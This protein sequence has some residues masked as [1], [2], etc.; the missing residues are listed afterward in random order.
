[1]THQQALVALR[2]VLAS[3]YTDATTARRVASD[4]GLD[5]RQVS[6]STRALDNWTAILDEAEKQ[7]L[8]SDLVGIARK[9]YPRY[10][11]LADAAAAYLA[12]PVTPAAPPTS[13]SA[14]QVTSPAGPAA[15]RLLATDTIRQLTDA[16]VPAGLATPDARD[17]LLQGIYPGFVA[18]LPVRSSP[19]D[20][21]RSDL[22]AMN[23]VP[24]LVDGQVPLR[25]WLE[26]AVSRLRRTGYPEMASFQMVL[27][28]LDRAGEPR[29][30]PI[31]ASAGEPYSTIPF[32][33][34]HI[35]AGHFW[36]GSNRAQDPDALDNEMQHSVFLPEYRIARFPVTVAQFRR[37][38]DSTGYPTT[39]E[40]AGQAADLVR[41]LTRDEWPPKKG[42]CWRQPHGPGSRAH[43]EHPVTCISWYDAVEFCKWAKVRLPNE[44]EW[45]KAAGW[46]PQAQLKRI[47]PWGDQPP[48]ENRSNFNMH[49]GD[50]TPVDHYPD[51][52]SWYGV[53]DMAGNVWEWTSS[54]Y[55]KYPYAL[56]DRENPQAAGEHVL[57][58]GSFYQKAINVRCAYRNYHR[59]EVAVSDYGFRVCA[60][61]G[62]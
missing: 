35:P 41:G 60:L 54:L 37:F 6:F 49:V 15:R 50:T 21:V 32:D 59:P 61:S 47:Y 7:G 55:K 8:V 17:E 13:P 4:A 9:E 44:A 43:D 57:R 45:E 28:E 22:A 42:V 46:D 2:D 51:G 34:V 3:L 19:L 38:T 31:P 26:N 12:S 53:L 56:D 5:L 24:A 33:W 48:A 20:Q 39:A 11:P 23:Q 10:Q 30:P 16:L 25:I 27:A 36:M 29:R 40:D 58:G 62:V 1:M 52:A 14:G 18:S